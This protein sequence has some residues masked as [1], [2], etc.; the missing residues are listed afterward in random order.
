MPGSCKWSLPSG[1]PHQNPVYT[2]TL[3]HMCYM[4]FLLYLIT[5]TIMSEEY[6]SL[7][8]SLCSILHYLVTVCLSPKY[9]PQ[10]PILKH[11]QPTFVPQCE[12]PSSTPI[13]HNSQ[14]SLNF[15]IANWKTKDSVPHDSKHSL[16][17]ICSWFLPEQNFDLLRLFPNIWTLPPFFYQLLSTIFTL[18]LCPA[19]WS[20]DMTKYLVISTFT[21]SP[22]SLLPINKASAF[23]FTVCTLLGPGVA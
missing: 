1:F 12:R 13:Q 20:Q 14:K 16:T 22:I 9:S 7:S 19:F 18:W 8:S 3:P 2:S 10:R 15:W 17:S 4:P 5:W 11:P 6:T 21:S 23:S